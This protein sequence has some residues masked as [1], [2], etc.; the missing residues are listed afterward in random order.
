MIPWKSIEK[1]GFPK[2]GQRVM[3][4][5]ANPIIGTEIVTLYGRDIDGSGYHK[6]PFITHW[7][8]T[9]EIEIP[10]GIPPVRREP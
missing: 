10:E 2:R 1:D 5:Q 8:P 6:E 3:A 9:S 7:C 4:V